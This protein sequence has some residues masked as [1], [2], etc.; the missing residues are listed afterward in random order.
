MYVVPCYRV[1]E[2]VPCMAHMSSIVY[3]RP[4]VIP[5]NASSFAWNELILETK[6]MDIITRFLI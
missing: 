3:G 4:A 6:R 1:T 5:F 2:I